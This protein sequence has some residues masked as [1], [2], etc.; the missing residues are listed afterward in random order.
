[1]QLDRIIKKLVSKPTYTLTAI[2]TLG[3][4]LRLMS[5]IRSVTISDDGVGYMR[6]AE[7]FATGEYSATFHAVYPPLYPFFISL[8][9]NLTGDFE[10][11]GRLVSLIFGTV[12]IAVA[13]SLAKLIYNETI[14]LLTALLVAI[15]PYMI[16][17]SGEVLTEGLYY[18][19]F[20]LTVLVG[21]KALVTK[22]T[23]Y[24]VLVGLLSSMAYLTRP[25]GIALLPL[26]FIWLFFFNSQNIYSDIP[27]K[28]YLAVI[29]TILFLL[30]S[31]PYLNFVYESTS[32]TSIS[33][34]SNISYAVA[35]LF[36]ND[37]ALRNFNMLTE[38]FVPAFTVPLFILFI[39]GLFVIY[40]SQPKEKDYF[41]LSIIAFYSIVYIVVR[42]D[43]RYF[44]ELMSLYLIFSAHGLIF[45]KEFIE[46]SFKEK[47]NYSFYIIIFLI[48]LFGS[49]QGM[50]IKR[51]HVAE[52]E[53]ALWLKATYGKGIKIMTYNPTVLGE[54]PIFVYYSEG[55]HFTLPK[56]TFK[57]AL[58][59][60]REMG[61]EVIS[62]YENV[63]KN[64]YKDFNKEV[65]AISEIKRLADKKGE[66]YV[67]YHVTLP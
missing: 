61:I 2:L 20:T 39:L 59:M 67:V 65:L 22:N 47:F 13:Y 33:G 54:L 36:N 38:N 9:S 31:L 6:V 44:V 11:A 57:D 37:L 32:G 43:T 35:S 23:V 64:K 25:E 50:E 21:Y 62:G 56:G 10:T 27:R 58:E 30:A 51:H 24:M 28:I 3:F 16:R 18:T 7:G 34:K 52:K 66:D 14:G 19:I 17:Y 46:K 45:I 41:L 49:Y 48:T 60:A 29:G 1:M 55:K 15:H 12:A 40:K 5:F 8:F 53:T 26:T 63:L 4:V 42:P